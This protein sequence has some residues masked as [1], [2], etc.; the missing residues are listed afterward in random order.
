MEEAF[1][2]DMFR[3]VNTPFYHHYAAPLRQ[4]MECAR[5]AANA[6]GYKALWWPFAPPTPM[7]RPWQATATTGLCHQHIHQTTLSANKEFQL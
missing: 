2:A 3:N 6:D 5:K 4:T 7:G 1:P